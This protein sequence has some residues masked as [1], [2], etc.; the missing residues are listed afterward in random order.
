VVGAL[1]SGAVLLPAAPALADVNAQPGN[2]TLKPGEQKSITITL[3]G[4]EAVDPEANISVNGLGDD[5]TLRGPGG[6]QAGGGGLQCNENAFDQ[7]GA[8]QK[9]TITVQAKN[10]GS[11]QPGQNKEGSINVDAGNDDDSVNVALQGPQQA[12][13]VTEV[14]G[15]ITSQATGDG[16][17]GAQVTLKDSAGKTHDATANNQGNYSIK[18]SANNPIAA[19]QVTVTVTKEGFTDATATGNAQ[20]GKALTLGVRMKPTAASAEPSAPVASDPPPT[21]DPSGVASDVATPQNTSN[22][23]DG[24]SKLSWVLIGMGILLVLLGIGAIVLLVMRRKDDTEGDDADPYGTNPQMAPAGA[25][26]YGAD[27]TMVG[28]RSNANDQTAIVGPQLDEFPDPYAAAPVAAPTRVGG[29]YNGGYEGGQST[30]VAPGYGGPAAPGAPGGDYGNG[31]GD[32]YGANGGY[33][34]ERGYGAQQ[35]GYPDE[36]R[37][38]YGGGAGGGAGGGGYADQPTGVYQGNGANGSEYGANG[39]GYG[40]GAAGGGANGYGPGADGYEDEYGRRGGN[41]DYE[42][43]Y[44]RRGD[45]QR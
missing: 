12:A 31:R 34:D 43:G 4:A 35:G 19:G 13:S 40:G 39:S 27:R 32:G 18:P 23:S 21:D 6:C 38:G 7:D 42:G 5:V 10:P 14:S 2:L 15:K 44:G 36:P 33:R 20:A 1:V 37:G 17:A 30:S 26:A 8:Q 45:Y 29:A 41:G 3:T 25:G 28:G 24:P 16:V 9:L 11:L 22:E